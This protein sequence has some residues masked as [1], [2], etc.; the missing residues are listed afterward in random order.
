MY[1]G[2]VACSR[3][4]SVG[5]LMAIDEHELARTICPPPCCDIARNSRPRFVKSSTA[6]LRHPNGAAYQGLARPSARTDP[7]RYAPIHWPVNVPF[8]TSLF[9]TPARPTSQVSSH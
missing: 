2:H 7:R 3:A 6:R 9:L 5:A 8:R 1:P 4:G